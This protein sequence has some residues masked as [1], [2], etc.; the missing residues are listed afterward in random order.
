MPDFGTRW[1]N[2]EPLDK[3]GQAQTFIV[4]DADNPNSQPSVAKILNNPRKDRKARFLQEIEVTESFDHPNV[5]RSLGR[6]ETSKS[7]WP[8]FVM[9]YYQLGALETNNEKLGTPV[10]RLKVSLRFVKA[11]PTR[12]ERGLITQAVYTCAL[13][14]PPRFVFCVHPDLHLLDSRAQNLLRSGRRPHP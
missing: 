7:R 2:P 14:P 9:P 6:G 10:E 11:L 12:T 8:F 3:G 4:H 5:V 13:Q 1:I